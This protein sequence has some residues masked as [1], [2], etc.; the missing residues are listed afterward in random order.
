MDIAKLNRIKEKIKLSGYKLKPALSE[1]EVN[2]FEKQYGIILPDDYRSFIINTGNGGDGPPYYGMYNL[3]E[4]YTHTKEFSKKSDAFLRE[5]F[6]LKEY[7]VW[8]NEVHVKKTV[9]GFLLGLSQF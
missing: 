6:P 9:R 2:I 4:A 5:E 3:N 8:E 7:W 1:E